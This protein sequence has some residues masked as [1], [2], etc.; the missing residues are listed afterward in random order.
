LGRAFFFVAFPL[1]RQP[2]Y[3]GGHGHQLCGLR[4]GSGFWRI[5]PNLSKYAQMYL[6]ISKYV[7]IC[8]NLSHTAACVREYF[9]GVSAICQQHFGDMPEYLRIGRLF[10]VDRYFAALYI[11]IRWGKK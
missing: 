6:N 1:R 10:V 2:L 4:A 7:H 3:V 9:G 8:P 5:Y 11:G